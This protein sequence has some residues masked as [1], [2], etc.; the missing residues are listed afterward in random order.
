MLTHKIFVN[1]ILSENLWG[2]EEGIRN[3]SAHLIFAFLKIF[4]FSQNVGGIKYF[5]V[6][7][8]PKKPSSV[9]KV[10]SNIFRVCVLKKIGM[11]KRRFNSGKKHHRVEPLVFKKFRLLK[12]S[13]QA[14]GYHDFSGKI[15]SHIPNRGSIRRNRRRL[16][17]KRKVTV[18][19]M[20]VIIMNH[21]CLNGTFHSSFIKTSTKDDEWVLTLPM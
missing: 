20:Y 8:L 17:K 1:Y 16:T 11:C 14:K 12:I 19:I 5:L 10:I 2:V 7:V 6:L 18:I 9:R 4:D 3:F 15:L 13:S 21:N